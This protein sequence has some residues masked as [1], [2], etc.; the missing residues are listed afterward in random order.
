MLHRSWLHLLHHLAALCPLCLHW[1]SRLSCMHLLTRVL[2]PHLQ[3][4]SVVDPHPRGTGLSPTPCWTVKLTS[5]RQ[6][7]PL[8]N[9][10]CKQEG[11]TDAGSSPWKFD[12][13]LLIWGGGPSA[14]T[15]PGPPGLF[16]AHSLFS[17]G[18]CSSL[19]KAGS[20][21]P[22]T[23]AALLTWWSGP[24]AEWLSGPL[25]TQGSCLLTRFPVPE[26]RFEA[27]HPPQPLAGLVWVPPR[28][29]V[30]PCPPHRLRSG[31][32]HL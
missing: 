28:P 24:M 25:G 20:A 27:P 22:S 1:E 4:L 29:Q 18:H 6:L 23:T 19:Q 30:P 31:D 32:G 11:L 16:L 7:L 2:V 26:G 9:P 5:A 15:R 17:S 10:I 12:Q 13:G 21:F 8:R 3:A 14:L